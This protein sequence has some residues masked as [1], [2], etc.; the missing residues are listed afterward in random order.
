MQNIV[1]VGNSGS[2]KTSFVLRLTENTFTESFISTVGKDMTIVEYNNKRFIL[3][4]TAGQK[5]FAILCE[6][7]YKYAHGAIVFYE[8]C[9][10][11]NIHS[12]VETLQ[13]EQKDIPIILVGNKIDECPNTYTSDYPHVY[14][15]CK[16]GENVDKVLPLIEPMLKEVK[17]LPDETWTEL[18]QRLTNCVCQ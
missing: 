14:I 13:E 5:R 7:Y 17:I 18:L 3:H 2:G 11:S 4:D 15:S 9:D 6:A 10:T 16:T 12:W 8:T 1:L